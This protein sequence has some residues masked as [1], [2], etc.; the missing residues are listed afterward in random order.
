M[1]I[2][3]PKN[4]IINENRNKKPKKKPKVSKTCFKNSKMTSKIIIKSYNLWY[5]RSR[6]QNFSLFLFNIEF[7]NYVQSIN[8]I[9]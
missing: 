7:Y 8:S 2:P 4:Y 6:I 5:N 3:K 9:N 1:K